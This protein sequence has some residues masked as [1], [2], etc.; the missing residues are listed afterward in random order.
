MEGRCRFVGVGGASDAVLNGRGAGAGAVAG[1][2]S[3]GVAVVSRG[4]Y[5]IAPKP[6]PGQSRNGAANVTV[7][8]R[9]SGSR[10][11][12]WAVRYTTATISCLDRDPGGGASGLSRDAVHQRETLGN[13]LFPR[14]TLKCFVLALGSSRSLA[15]PRSPWPRRLPRRTRRRTARRPA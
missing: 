10:G 8:S 14:Q 9:A 7:R 6:G 2:D 12:G 11:V 15:W 4:S 13:S 1:M 3:G 5:V